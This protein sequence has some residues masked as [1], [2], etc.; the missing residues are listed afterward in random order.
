[1]GR[2]IDCVPDIIPGSH[3]FVSNGDDPPETKLFL[4]AG[5]GKSG[6]TGQAIFESCGLVQRQT[7]A[8]WIKLRKLKK[9][10]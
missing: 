4:Y 7:R 8:I 2:G 10:N 5:Y 1:M 6:T 3:P 9:S